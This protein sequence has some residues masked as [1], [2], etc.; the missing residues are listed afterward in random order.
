[1]ALVLV[2]L[3][4]LYC[5]GP[6][7]KT[8]VAATYVNVESGRL[9]YRGSGFAAEWGEPV[10]HQ[11][12]LRRIE[13]ARYKFAPF[14]THHAVVTTGDYSDPALVTVSPFRGGSIVW[15]AQTAPQGTL[16]VLHFIPYDASI[17]AQ[18]ARLDD[19]DCARF[20][21]REEKDGTIRGDDGAYSRLNSAN[22][23]YLLVEAVGACT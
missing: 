14:F 9:E 23:R 8:V 21:G 6:S 10:V 11:G 3:G 20:V 12:D 22:H 13:R 17:L 7:A 5:R 16:I 18:L 15:A 4:V 1:M 19:G 2:G